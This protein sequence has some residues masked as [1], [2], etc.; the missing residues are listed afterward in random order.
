MKVSELIAQLQDM[1]PDDE[2]VVEVT[3]S[4][5]SIGPSAA[6]GVVSAA[7]GLDWNNGRVLLGTDETVYAGLAGFNAAVSFA[8]A[9]RNAIYFRNDSKHPEQRD[10]LAV[11]AIE[12]GISKWYPK[13]TPEE[14]SDP[15]E[16]P[17]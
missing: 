8:R 7:N 11:Q 17:K 3:R 12:R 9:V 6:V 1:E 14:F 13:R 5:P 4:S 2:V 16:P 15:A 10:A